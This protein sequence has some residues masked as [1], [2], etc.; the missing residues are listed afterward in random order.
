MFLVTLW[1]TY[2]A[3]VCSG[4]CGRKTCLASLMQKEV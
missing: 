3:K 4:F 2:F 1:L